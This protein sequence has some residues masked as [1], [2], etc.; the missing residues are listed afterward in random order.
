[1]EY[2]NV[3]GNSKGRLFQGRV[4]VL[5]KLKFFLSHN[6]VNELKNRSTSIDANE[7]LM[8][9]TI[10]ILHFVRKPFGN[11]T[12]ARINPVAFKLIKYLYGVRIQ[13]LASVNLHSEATQA[14]FSQLVTIA[15]KKAQN[16]TAKFTHRS[17][18]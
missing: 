9:L 7:G 4:Y 15:F 17:L 12:T 13:K 8:F 14:V 16:G 11:L 6:I 18:I 3:E 5:D 1:M 2:N 10:L